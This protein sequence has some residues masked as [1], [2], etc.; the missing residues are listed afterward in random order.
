MGTLRVE[1]AA[2]KKRVEALT[3]R[4]VEKVS[5]RERSAARNKHTKDAVA[6]KKKLIKQVQKL[7]VRMI[8]LENEVVKS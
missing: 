7:L 1:K 3:W 5:V 8:E 4:L 6:G 2:Q